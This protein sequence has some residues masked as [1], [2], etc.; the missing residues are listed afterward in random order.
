MLMSSVD[1]ALRG[2]TCAL[3]LLIAATLLRDHGTLIAARLA[4]LFAIGTG[5]YAITSA[6]GFSGQLGSWTVPLLALS[7][8]NNVVFWTLTASLFDDGFRLRW[9]HVAL[10]LVLVVAGTMACFLSWRTLGIGLTLSSFAFA[11]L[12]MAQAMASWRADLV[13]GRRRLRLFVVGASSLY[14]GLMATAQL[15]GLQRSA[16]ADTSLVGA[17]GMLAIV[18]IIAWSLL[19]VG[20]K[21]SLFVVSAEL[22]QPVEEP[23]APP[24]EPGSQ[25]LVARL[26]VLMTAERAYRQDGLTIGSLAQQLGLPEYRLRRLINQALGYRNFNSFVNRYRIAE[27]KAALADPRQAEVPVLTMALD[28]GFSSL[29]PFNRAFKAETGVTPSEFRRLAAEKAGDSGIGQPIADS[30]SPLSNSARSNLA[31]H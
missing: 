17:I 19:S 11:A 12:A 25:Q 29:G 21:Q 28:A 10:W 30:I 16:P 4:A 26:E 7:A 27:V 23:A 2:G 8:G 14:I 13:E 6:A 24:L 5:A 3:V 9:W 1:W 15:A 20:R 31:A 18:G 22:P